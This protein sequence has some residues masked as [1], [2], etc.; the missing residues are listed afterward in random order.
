MRTLLVLSLSAVLFAS[1]AKPVPTN[2][3]DRNAAKSDLLIAG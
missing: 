2:D 1:C 3:T